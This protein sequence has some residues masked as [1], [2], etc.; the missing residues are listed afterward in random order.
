MKERESALAQVWTVPVL[1]RSSLPPETEC[2]QLA[3]CHWPN[4]LILGSPQCSVQS[5]LEWGV[6]YRKLW[7][8]DVCVSAVLPTGQPSESE[9]LSHWGLGQMERQLI[10]G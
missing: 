6:S 8:W 9:S 3:V 1:S 4:A 5:Q 7:G 10:T 2:L